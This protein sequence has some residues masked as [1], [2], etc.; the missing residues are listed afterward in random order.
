MWFTF[1]KEDHTH[2][3]TDITESY[4]MWMCTREVLENIISAVCWMPHRDRQA[5]ALS[6]HGA[7]TLRN[8]TSPWLRHWG[9]LG[10]Q[11]QCIIW[12]S[13]LSVGCPDV[14]VLTA[15]WTPS[16]PEGL[17]QIKHT[18]SGSPS[19]LCTVGEKG[20]CVTSNRLLLSLCNNLISLLGLS[21]SE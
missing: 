6:T 4:W 5:H 9:Q 1:E 19:P 21:M 14:A 7:D 17:D 18:D 15:L 16:A 13:Q 11:G 12:G 10:C 20:V 2:T 8:T 3:R